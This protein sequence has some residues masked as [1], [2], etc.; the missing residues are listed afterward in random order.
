LSYRGLFLARE[1]GDLFFA[2]VLDAGDKAG[3][4]VSVFREQRGILNKGADQ[5]R[6]A[7]LELSE[8][9]RGKPTGEQLVTGIPDSVAFGVP[10]DPVKSRTAV[11]QRG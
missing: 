3:R 5:R 2:R 11:S 1:D 8:R 4:D 10:T 9:D 6:L 7:A